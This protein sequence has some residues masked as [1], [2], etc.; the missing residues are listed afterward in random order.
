MGEFLDDGL[1]HRWVGVSKHNWPVAKDVIN[2]PI[3]IHVPE[4]RALCAAD[5]PG[6]ASGELVVLQNGAAGRSPSITA[7]TATRPLL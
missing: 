4:V 2:V 7:F 1:G 5:V 6:V 3:T